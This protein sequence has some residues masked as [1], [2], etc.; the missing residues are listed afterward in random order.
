MAFFDFPAQHWQSIRTSNPVGS[1][2]GGILIWRSNLTWLFFTA[3]V[4]GL[5]DVGYF[6]FMDL[7]GHVHFIPGTVMT[8]VSGSAIVFSLWVWLSN[9]GK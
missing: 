5:T 8:I 3:I 7:G 6:L 1:V 2:L 9:R 4:G